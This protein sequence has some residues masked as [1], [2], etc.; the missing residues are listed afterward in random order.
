MTPRTRRLSISTLVGALVG[1]SVAIAGVY[2]TRSSHERHTDLHE[3]LHEAVPLDANERE[4]LYQHDIGLVRLRRH[5]RRLAQEQID[6][7]SAS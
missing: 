7:G 2:V 6:E 5:L 1:I 3:M 4:N